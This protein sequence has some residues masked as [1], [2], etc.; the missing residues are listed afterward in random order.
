MRTVALAILS[1]CDV[2]YVFEC[3]MPIFFLIRRVT[4]FHPSHWANCRILGEA[5]HTDS[6][7][8]LVATARSAT[9]IYSAA[10]IL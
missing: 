7:V 2:L 8:A 6:V 1:K 5:L 4:L 10:H 9:C 3:V